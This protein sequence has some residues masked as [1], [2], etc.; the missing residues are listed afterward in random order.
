MFHK[1]QLSRTKQGEEM[2]IKKKN[3]KKKTLESTVP[4]PEET[5]EFFNAQLGVLLTKDIFKN[6]G[7][8]DIEIHISSFLYLQLLRYWGTELH[9]LMSIDPIYC[10]IFIDTTQKDSI[11]ILHSPLTKVPK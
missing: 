2:V 8:N 9:Q 4:S 1:K 5:I 3:L 7:F 10:R 11:N 6:R